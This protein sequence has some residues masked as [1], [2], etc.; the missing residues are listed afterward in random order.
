MMLSDE[1][2]RDTK[3]SSFQL[4]LSAFLINIGIPKTPSLLIFLQFSFPFFHFFL[5]L[6]FCKKIW[7]FNMKRMKE[8]TQ[9]N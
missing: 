1:K 7:Y 9:E 3:P 8:K 2:S 5:N 4:L 6:K